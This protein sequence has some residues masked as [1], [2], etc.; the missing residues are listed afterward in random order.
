[1]NR[2][3]KSMHDRR[4]ARA[5]AEHVCVLRAATQR[6][7]PRASVMRERTAVRETE[8]QYKTTVTSTKTKD[9][10]YGAVTPCK[11]RP[12]IF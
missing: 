5:G 7:A 11:E 1:M 4:A 9:R 10:V 12:E 2:M 6:L 8:S 3:C